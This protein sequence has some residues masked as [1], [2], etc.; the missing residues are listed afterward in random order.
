MFSRSFL[1]F[2]GTFKRAE[3]ELAAGM[4]VSAMA[5]CGDRW[6]PMGPVDFGKWIRLA[7]ETDSPG[8]GDWFKGPAFRLGLVRPDM[9]SLVE[10]GWARW[11]EDGTEGR[12]RPIEFT[13]AFFARLVEKGWV[14]RGGRG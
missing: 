10:H 4:L 14:R 11:V 3:S 9:L 8:W 12:R 1:P 6:Q 7:S 5:H 13:D 2:I